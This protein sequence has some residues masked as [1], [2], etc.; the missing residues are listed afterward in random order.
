MPDVESWRDVAE[1]DLF[2]VLYV[3]IVCCS[4]FLGI[5]VD[6]AG[7]NGNLWDVGWV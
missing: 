7:I 4:F 5:E 3:F 6:I 1:M 2:R